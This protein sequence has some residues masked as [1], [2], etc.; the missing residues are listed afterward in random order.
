[1]FLDILY[2]QMAWEIVYGI[3]PKAETGKYDVKWSDLFAISEAELVEIGVKRAEAL[4]KYA[5]QPVAE[6]IVSPQAF[7]EMFLGLSTEQIEQI[8][9]MQQNDINEENN[10]ESDE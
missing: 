2:S 5:S 9:Q 4:A 7:Y 1:M 6:A 8:Q 10:L 3:L